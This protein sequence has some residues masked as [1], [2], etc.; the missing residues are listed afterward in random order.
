[1][2]TYICTLILVKISPDKWITISKV[3]DITVFDYTISFFV[4]KSKLLAINK[5]GTQDTQENFL[6][7]F[8]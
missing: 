3:E 6:H 2:R 7:F 8:E 1:M 4:E 5:L